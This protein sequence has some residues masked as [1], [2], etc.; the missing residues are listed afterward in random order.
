ML[1]TPASGK[2][3]ALQGCV[4]S[5]ELPNNVQLESADVLHS[6]YV[7]ALRLKQDA[8]PG[9]SIP[10][11]FSPIREGSYEI[12]CAELCGPVHGYMKNTIVVV[13]PEAFDAWLREQKGQ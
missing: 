11:W 2:S 5:T 3:I 7:P 6:L 9:R 10:G 4:F 8:V 13:S 1:W 12:A